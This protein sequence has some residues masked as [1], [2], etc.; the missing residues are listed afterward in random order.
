MDPLTL[1]TKSLGLIDN[2]VV[3]QN[4]TTRAFLT[5]LI[6]LAMFDKGKE[7]HL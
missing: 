1:K 5:S 4:F 3:W 2:C 7:P 6:Y